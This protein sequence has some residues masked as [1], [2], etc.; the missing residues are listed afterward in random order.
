MDGNVTIY[1]ASTIDPALWSSTNNFS[2]TGVALNSTALTDMVSN[3]YLIFAVVNSDYD[4]K[5]QDGA[6]L[7]QLRYPFYTANMGSTASDPKIDYTLAS[8]GYGN[9]VIGVASANI[10]EINGVASGDISELN[11]L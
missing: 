11:G 4:Y 9:D 1:N 10:G 6:P 5:N 8:T 3:D 7:A 2:G